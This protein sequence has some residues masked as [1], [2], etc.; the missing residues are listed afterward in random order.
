MNTLKKFVAIII[1]ITL[2][3]FFVNVYNTVTK[4]QEDFN[5]ITDAA[6]N[7]RDYIENTFNIDSSADN[8]MKDDAEIC[9][10]SDAKIVVLYVY[11]P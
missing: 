1:I 11:I 3:L 6:K 8:V 9:V 2:I 7:V 10:E 4:S 5:V